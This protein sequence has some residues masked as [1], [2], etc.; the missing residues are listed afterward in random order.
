LVIGPGRNE[1]K[2]QQASLFNHALQSRTLT[3]GVLK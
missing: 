3:P 1:Y 2:V